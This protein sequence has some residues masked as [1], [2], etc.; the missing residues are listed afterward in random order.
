[1]KKIFGHHFRER[2]G[3]RVCV[4]ERERMREREK[5]RKRKRS[6]ARWETLQHDSNGGLVDAGDNKSLFIYSFKF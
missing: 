6:K 2:L 3:E 1:L 4:R 5:K